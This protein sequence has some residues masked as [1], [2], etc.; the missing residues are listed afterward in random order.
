MLGQ[1]SRPLPTLC[2]NAEGFLCMPY[3]LCDSDSV[4]HKKGARRSIV[5]TKEVINDVRQR[6]EQDPI[7]HTK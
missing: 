7:K 1:F 2:S 6:I 5:R 4:T 3:K